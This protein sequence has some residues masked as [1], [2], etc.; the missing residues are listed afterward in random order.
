MF[1]SSWVKLEI[2]RRVLSLVGGERG[3]DIRPKTRRGTGMA[4][5]SG[6]RGQES[7]DSQALDCEDP[8]NKT[9]SA[10]GSIPNC[11]GRIST[12]P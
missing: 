3:A 1:G 6:E 7:R 11:S 12:C 9:S 8:P 10:L 2:Q 4:R 5:S